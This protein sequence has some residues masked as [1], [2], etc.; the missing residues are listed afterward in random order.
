MRNFQTVSRASLILG[1]GS[2]H[3][4]FCHVVVCHVVTGH[5]PSCRIFRIVC[6][7][8]RTSCG[9]LSCHGIPCH[10]RQ[11]HFMFCHSLLANN[12]CHVISCEIL[13]MPMCDVLPL[14]IAIKATVHSERHVRNSSSSM[15]LKCTSSR[16]LSYTNKKGNQNVHAR[17]L[18]AFCYW[19]N[20]F[21]N[22]E[23]VDSRLNGHDL[24][25]E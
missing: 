15:H 17:T 12:S 4:V 25:L 16:D 7:T 23:D 6:Q 3:D 8:K 22:E 5:A 2:R 24:Q 1:V 9:P 10:G 21:V 13:S 14:F 18:N 19:A 11:H 20:C